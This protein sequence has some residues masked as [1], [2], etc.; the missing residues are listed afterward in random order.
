MPQMSSIPDSYWS[1]HLKEYI[2]ATRRVG[3]LWGLR[4]VSVGLGALVDVGL[5]ASIGQFDTRMWNIRNLPSDYQ[6]PEFISPL[7]SA[8]Y[9][10]QMYIKLITCLHRYG[11]EARMLQFN[12]IASSIG[13]N[14]HFLPTS[15]LYPTLQ[16]GRDTFCPMRRELFIRL[17]DCANIRSMHAS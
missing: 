1:S 10:W 3:S 13:Q 12:S 2:E 9:R 8:L 17:T 11:Y 16:F 14:I 7:L 5:G 6:M 4:K 15:N